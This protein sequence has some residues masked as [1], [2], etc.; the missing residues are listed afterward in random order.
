[1]NFEEGVKNC[2]NC[3]HQNVCMKYY[4]KSSIF[5]KTEETINLVGEKI[6][7]DCKYFDYKEMKTYLMDEFKEVLKEKIESTK[8]A[9]CLLVIDSIFNLLG[10]RE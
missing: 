8:D 1:M 4:N 6:A 2:F 10:G 5:L 3:S 7:K 9:N